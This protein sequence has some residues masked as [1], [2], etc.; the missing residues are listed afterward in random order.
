[1][2]GI[3]EYGRFGEYLAVRSVVGARDDV[4]TATAARLTELQQ[5]RR[6]A[7]IEKVRD[8]SRFDIVLHDR[9]LPTCVQNR[10]GRTH[11]SKV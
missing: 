8:R 7:V 4:R 6:A 9:S 3:D 10:I 5:S 1:M 2:P 11:A